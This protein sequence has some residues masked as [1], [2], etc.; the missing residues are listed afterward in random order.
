VSLDVLKILFVCTGNICRSPTAEGVF[1]HL[2][3]S[4]GLNDQI[5]SDSAGTGPWRAGEAPDARSQQTALSHGIDISH[6]RARSIR[7]NDFHEFN[8]IIAMDSS[9]LQSMRA[10]CPTNYANR[11]RLF[12]E[13]APEIGI[14]DVP[15]PYYGAEDGFARIFDVIT[16]AALGLLHDIKTNRLQ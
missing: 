14:I 4:Q 16:A 5:T 13:Y 1:Q 9:H 15:D 12:M 3:Q 10:N 11:L 8:L 2:V 6:Q 7:E